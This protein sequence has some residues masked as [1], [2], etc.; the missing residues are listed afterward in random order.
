M[1]H[2]VLLAQR[3]LLVDVDGDEIDVLLVGDLGQDG[4]QDL[5]G[6]AP[7]DEEYAAKTRSVSQGRVGGD[8]KDLTLTK[9]RRS[10]P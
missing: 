10:R 4:L 7:M 3:S 2:L 6:A 5:A 9:A 8:R 1:T